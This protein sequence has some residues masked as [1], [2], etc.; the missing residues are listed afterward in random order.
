MMKK[1]NA[2]S[3]S[4]ETHHPE[5]PIVMLAVFTDRYGREVNHAETPWLEVVENIAVLPEAD[6]KDHCPMIKLAR[7]GDKKTEKGSFRHDNNVMD[8]YGIEADYDAGHMH[9]E[10]AFE[11]ISEHNICAVVFETWSSTP[12]YPRWRALVPFS[13]KHPP[14]DRCYYSEALNGMLDGVLAPESAVLSQAYYLGKPIG[15][16]RK[17][18]EVKGSRCIDQLSRSDLNALRY[19]FKSGT[20]KGKTLTQKSLSKREYKTAPESKKN[21]ISDNL[22]KLADGVDVH[23]NTLRSVGRLVSKGLNDEEIF[24]VI[25][26]LTP[27]IA[28]SQGQDRVTALVNGELQRMIEGAREKC[29]GPNH[30]TD[31]GNAERLRFRHGQNSRYCYEAGKWLNWFDDRWQWDEDGEINRKAAE[32]V[33]AIYPDAQN[34]EDDDKRLKLV[35]HATKSEARSRIENMIELSQTLEGLPLSISELD[36]DPM[37]IGIVGGTLNLNDNQFL[38]ARREDYITK[39]ANVKFIPEAQCPK[40]LTFLEEILAADQTLITYMQQIVGYCMTGDTSEQCLF[41]FHGHGANGKSVFLNVIQRMLGDYAMDT[42]PETLMETKRSNGAKNDIARLRG[43]RFVSS[44]EPNDGCVFAEGV[45][46]QLTGQDKVT[47]RFLYKEYFEYIPQFKIV[48]ITN[49]KPIIKGDD[50]AIWRRVKLIPFEVTIPPEKQVKNLANNL[51][52]EELPGILNWALEGL[53]LWREKGFV[54]P[55]AVEKATQE[56]RTEMDILGDWLNEHC[57]VAPALGFISTGDLYDSYKKFC[58]KE[59]VNALNRRAFGRKLSERGFKPKKGTGGIR[60]FQGIRL[61]GSRRPPI[62]NITK[63]TNGENKS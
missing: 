3:L 25:N 17:Y 29:F 12:E 60:G 38:S 36:A 47:C 49:H 21:E 13:Q 30:L 44:S 37:L 52:E 42:P 9:L 33:R 20:H 63:I 62:T 31:L 16:N 40:W 7:F 55:E 59:N 34:I 4:T 11:K 22:A 46:K 15:E 41:V 10:D 48:L 26:S 32:T 43:A 61:K 6:A 45:V 56:Y 35:T 39:R 24:S 14:E 50:H 1:T 28:A 8:V 27:Q 2:K 57:I 53:R 19:P 51:I 58:Y 5:N 23:G 54:P 18:L